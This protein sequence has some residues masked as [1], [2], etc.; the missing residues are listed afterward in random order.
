MKQSI[1]KIYIVVD[2]CSGEDYSN[3]DPTILFVSSN[4]KEAKD[5]FND[6]ISNWEDGLE[7]FDSNCEELSGETKLIYECTDFD[8]DSHRIMKLVEKEIQ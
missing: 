8:G 6:E 4:Y 5:F 2:A 7:D 3:D 1:N